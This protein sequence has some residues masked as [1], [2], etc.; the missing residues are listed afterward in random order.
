MDK[1]GI[2]RPVQ[3][4]I[5]ALGIRNAAGQRD[6]AHNPCSERSRRPAADAILVHDHHERKDHMKISLILPLMIPLL[7]AAT[8]SRSSTPVPSAKPRVFAIAQSLGIDAGDAPPAR[9]RMVVSTDIGET[10][11]D[12]FQ[13]MVHLLVYADALDLEGLISSPCGPGRKEHI[14]QVIDHYARDYK[15]LRTYS[16]KYPTRM[17]CGR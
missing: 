3:T 6:D 17:P 7:T 2:F 13:S 5:F 11:P 16:G 1:M 10:D 14:L 4:V 12:D 8:L 15:N 9:P